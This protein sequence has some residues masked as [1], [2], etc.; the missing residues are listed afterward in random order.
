[1]LDIYAPIQYNTIYTPIYNIHGGYAMNREQ[2]LKQ[3]I[4]E[5]LKVDNYSISVLE[6]IK[7]MLLL[8]K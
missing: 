7:R 8:Q 5:L 2:E 6:V 4:T 1:M 3:I